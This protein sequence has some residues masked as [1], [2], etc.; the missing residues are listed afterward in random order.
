MTDLD[1]LRAVIADSV[2]LGRL[3]ENEKALNLLDT[4]IAE[5]IEE[6]R[7][8]W[9]RVLC[10]HASVIANSMGDLSRA[11]QYIEKCVAYDPDNPLPLYKLADVLLRQH[12]GDLAQKYAARSYK[13]SMQRG[14]ALDRG[15]IESILKQWPEIG[16]DS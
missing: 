3:G 6:D 5:A 4:S 15:I 9:I 7:V 14:T 10:G 2:E 8:P 1:G 13:L 12:E 11:R 16:A